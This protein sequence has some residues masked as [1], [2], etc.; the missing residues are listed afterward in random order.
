MIITVNLTC[1]Y[2]STNKDFV[3][4]HYKRMALEHPADRI[5]FILRKRYPL[6]QKLPENITTLS[7]GPVSGGGLLW[8][9]W[10]NF[11]LPALLRK[12]KAAVVI[13]ADGAC[14]L[15]TGVRQ[16]IFINEFYLTDFIPGFSRTPISSFAKKMPA[17][18]QKVAVI[19]AGSPHQKK[20]M[21]ERH[22]IAEDK[23]AVCIPAAG[24]GFRPTDFDEKEAV[25][26]AY[27]SGKEFFLYSGEITEPG[28][29]VKLLKAFSFFKKRQ[30][31]NMQLV[32]ATGTATAPGSFI[33]L[34]ETYKYRAEVKLFYDL[35]DTE[36]TRLMAAAYCF[37]YP[38]PAE[39]FP[40]SVMQAIQC[41][42]PMILSHDGLMKEIAL[43][44]A[45]YVDPDDFQDIADKMM[46][47]FKD[48]NKREVLIKNA[49]LLSRQYNSL[50][51]EA[52]L[53]QSTTG[54]YD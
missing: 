47:L 15:R 32:I 42:T 40:R 39:C 24:E 14:S 29:L 44:A 7:S 20:V 12:Y 16:C 2:S 35:P 18:L 30:K 41:E 4:D 10:Y 27:T 38:A 1:F 28:K 36:M 21:M 26:D 25:K 19:I 50:N 23:I 49:I 31:S 37:V 17:F 51:G 54:S 46:L 53:W 22:A 5:I 3:V 45:V 33:A 48:E 8:R 34:L 6:P 13:H 9:L 43:E 11:T 52:M